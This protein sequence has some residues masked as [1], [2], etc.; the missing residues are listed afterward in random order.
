MPI[1]QADGLTKTYRVFQKKAG[2]LNAVRSLV[3]RQYKEILAERHVHTDYVY[4]NGTLR[5]GLVLLDKTPDASDL[6]LVECLYGDGNSNNSVVFPVDIRRVQCYFR[7]RFDILAK[8]KDFLRR[9]GEHKYLALK[10]IDFKEDATGRQLEHNYRT[11][12]K[13]YK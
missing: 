12:F 5:K 10:G 6:E 11:L 3:R 8:N 1:I 4:H 9:L 7:F 2:L 13:I